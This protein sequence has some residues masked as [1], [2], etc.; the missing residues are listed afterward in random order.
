VETPFLLAQVLVEHAELLAADDRAG[1]A[2]VLAG[3]AREIFAE[4]RATPWLERAVRAL[5]PLE[6]A[7]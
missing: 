4:L 5:A 7:R 3:E 2:L 6:Q 1:D